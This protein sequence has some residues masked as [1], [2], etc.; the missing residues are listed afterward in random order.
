MVAL[1]EDSYTV[2]T[3]LEK[4]INPSTGKFLLSTGTSY[5]DSLTSKANVSSVYSKDEVNT[6]TVTI[7]LAINNRQIKPLHI[8]KPRIRW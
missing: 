3:P 1:K 8:K 7:G 6:T 2:D 4:G 5:Y